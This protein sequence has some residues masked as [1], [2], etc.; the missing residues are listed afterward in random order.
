MPDKEHKVN[1][2]WNEKDNLEPIMK[3]GRKISELEG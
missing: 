2:I 1:G 3:R